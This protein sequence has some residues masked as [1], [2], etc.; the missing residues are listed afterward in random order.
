MKDARRKL[1]IEIDREPKR[2][3]YGAYIDFF[4]E[5]E[6]IQFEFDGPT[7]LLATDEAI[8][9]I[10][11]APDQPLGPLRENNL[12]RATIEGFA[13]AGE[14]EA[15]G[16]SLSLSLL[17]SAITK[18]FGVRLDYHSPLPCI[19]YDRIH[20]DPHS[21]SSRAHLSNHFPATPSDLA[22]LMTDVLANST[23]VDRQLLLSM[24]LYAGASLE[25]SDRAK[26]LGRVSALEPLATQ[27]RYPHSI[28]TLIDNFRQQLQSEELSDISS[29]D[30]AKFKA[31]L[32][33][34]LKQLQQESIRQALLRVVREVFSEDEEPVRAI[35]DAYALRSKMLHEGT[36]D[37]YLDRKTHEV[38][39]IIRRIYA[40]RVGK[41][42][43]IGN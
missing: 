19:V 30:K 33:A 13:T 3:P 22:E 38:E 5:E 35:D 32:D 14:A 36:T 42:L 41:P 12:Y 15:M 9:Q 1:F 20:F 23:I 26:F 11:L 10:H 43:K 31:S 17:W 7:S 8:V 28:T 2:R 18:D 16:L 6:S 4:V 34:R 40:A 21:G 37:P 25:I 39:R 24:E 27:N 29:A